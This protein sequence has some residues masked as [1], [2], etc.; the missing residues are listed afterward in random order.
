[1]PF[2]FTVMLSRWYQNKRVHNEFHWKKTKIVRFVLI[3]KKIVS[4]KK[5]PATRLA[6]DRRRKVKSPTE[7]KVWVANE[8]ALSFSSSIV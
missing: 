8:I 7:L 3:F 4:L 6:T 1:M 2:A 5:Q